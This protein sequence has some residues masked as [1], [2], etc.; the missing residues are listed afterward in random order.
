M[1]LVWMI[2][3]IV[4]ACPQLDSVALGVVSH[5]GIGLKPWKNSLHSVVSVGLWRMKRVSANLWYQLAIRRND[6]LFALIDKY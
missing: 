3:C 6:G 2:L 1:L 5:G 4:S